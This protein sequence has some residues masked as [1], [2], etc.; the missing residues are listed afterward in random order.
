MA[1]I[2]NSSN[3]SA[4]TLEN[5][6]RATLNSYRQQR[7]EVHRGKQLALERLRLVTE[8]FEVVQSSVQAAQKNLAAL[9]EKAGGSATARQEH[10]GLERDVEHL[11]KEVR[12]SVRGS[13]VNFYYFY[14]FF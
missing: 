14:Y 7:D 6:L 13:F 12:A 5:K 8:E 2:D 4:S 3:N 10:E 1:S 11:T 9:Q